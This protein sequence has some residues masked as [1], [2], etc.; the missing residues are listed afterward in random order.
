MDVEIWSDVMCPFCYIGKRKFEHALSQF[1]HK[2]QVNVVWKSFQLNP[3]MKSEPGKNVTQHLAEVKGWSLD[4]ARR[5]S[6]HV[7]AMAREVGLS[8]DF[9][10]AV[11]ANSWDAHRLIQLAKQHGL[12]DAAEER[13]FL[14]YFT[15]GRDTSD[16][17]TLLE[18]GTE[19]GLE[20]AAVQ[21]MLD[22]NQ[23][24][25]AVNQDIY[26]AQQVGARGVPFF[27][28]D[29]RYAVSGA[30]Q[31]DTFLS[32]LNTAWSDWS[33]ANPTVANVPTDGPACTPGE[34]C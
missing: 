5:M 24:A 12:G 16:H 8:Y 30:Q 1:P 2:E 19:I 29:R 9:D 11:V 20:A 31:P 6:D 23:F 18:L 21:Q 14:A 4:E 32:A 7:T 10:K 33:K 15:E 3:D 22:S 28:L 13:L 17:A 27:V 25:E 26:E 34:I